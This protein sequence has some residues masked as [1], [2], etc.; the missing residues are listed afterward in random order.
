ML[1]FELI[2]SRRGAKKKWIILRILDQRGPLTSLELGA[3]MDKF[4]TKGN[5]RVIGSTMRPMGR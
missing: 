4:D 3:I 2:G 1:V 5:S